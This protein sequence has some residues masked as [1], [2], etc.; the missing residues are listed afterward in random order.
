MEGAFVSRG[1][2]HQS[3]LTLPEWFDA[4][5]ID[6]GFLTDFR[7]LLLLRAE[8]ESPFAPLGLRFGKR[9]HSLSSVPAIGDPAQDPLEAIL[10]FPDYVD[11]SGWSVQLALSNVDAETAAEVSVEVFDEGGQPIRDLFD[12]ASAFQIPS[13]GS[14][15]LRSAGA[16][17]IRRGWI[18]V[19]SDPAS[20]SGLLTYRQAETGVE[21]S[22]KP[23]ALGSQ[24]ALFVEES[25]VIG[26]GV[27]HFQTGRLP[28]CRAPD[29]RR[30][31]QRSVERGVHPLGRLPPTGA[32]APGMARRG[33]GGYGI[34]E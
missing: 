22:V 12:S 5:G 17:A 30:G 32:H 25:S 9:N 21:V 26:A 19:E 13:L 23:V 1:N 7:G 24:F 16:G 34:P 6:R 20:V 28:E 2:F 4:E 33:R 11:G 8:D 29:P 3:A 10:Y 31:G 15:V 14:R 18:K 27:G